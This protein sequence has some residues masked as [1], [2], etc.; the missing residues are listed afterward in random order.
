MSEVTLFSPEDLLEMGGSKNADRSGVYAALQMKG[1]RAWTIR[2][3]GLTLVFGLV[4]RPKG[5]FLLWSILP[6]NFKPFHARIVKRVLDQAL[7]AVPLSLIIQVDP[8]FPERENLAKFLG[9]KP[10]SSNYWRRTS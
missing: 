3:P 10:V 4:S 1:D 8:A 6:V 7:A 2:A 5:E 9:F